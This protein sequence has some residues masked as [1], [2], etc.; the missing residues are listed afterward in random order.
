MRKI[1]TLILTVLGLV[2]AIVFNLLTQGKSHENTS[3]KQD[4]TVVRYTQELFIDPPDEDHEDEHGEPDDERI[5][6]TIIGSAA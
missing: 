4:Q 6:E 2:L 1:I 5:A 3:K